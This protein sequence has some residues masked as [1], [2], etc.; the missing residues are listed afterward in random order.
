MNALLVGTKKEPILSYLPDTFLLIDD[1]ELIDAIEIPP[2]KD[3][4][5]FDVS[6][7]SFNPLKDMDYRRARDFIS[8]LDAI[9]P[10]GE[11]T[12]TRKNANFILLNALLDKPKTMDK[13]V[14]PKADNAHTDAYQKIQTL[15]LSPILR[16]VL[17]R[18]TNFSFKGTILARLDRAV[19]GDFDCF[20]LGNL[21]I[22]QY[23]G[24]IVVPDFG[25]Y[26]Y[27]S[28]TSLLRQNRLIAGV[29]CLDEVPDLRG[30]LLLVNTKRASHATADD[31]KVLALYAG[32]L[33]GT[34][35]YNA[36]LENCI[37]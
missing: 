3:V 14:Y 22:S 25:F 26:A 27:P 4:T 8:V 20:V 7:H 1:G 17:N 10:E 13:L 33:P 9:F 32:L 21:L 31:A 12:L 18:P 6:R 30:Q 2:R 29:N 5:L 19:F 24:H 11:G 28:H 36:F 15:L 37:G 16:N 23:K 34:N 35:A